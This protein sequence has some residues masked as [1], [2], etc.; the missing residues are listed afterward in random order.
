MR[1]KQSFL[2]IY[3][4]VGT[5]AYGA[6][7]RAPHIMAAFAVVIG[8]VAVASTFASAGS[9]TE[10][11]PRIKAIVEAFLRRPISDAE[12]NQFYAEE[13]TDPSKYDADTL[14]ELDEVAATLR[15][16]HGKPAA[17]HRRH[18]LIQEAMFE[19]G[20]P[21]VKR[22]FTSLDPV[23]VTD[24]SGEKLMTEGDVLAFVQIVKFARTNTDPSEIEKRRGPKDTELAA[25]V[26]AELR[27]M[28][29]NGGRLPEM[30]PD[31]SAFWAGMVQNWASLSAQEKDAVRNYIKKNLEGT[32]TEMSD[33]LY[34]NLM[35]W[36]S[37]EYKMADLNKTIQVGAMWAR[38]R[39]HMQNLQYLHDTWS[40][41]THN[42]DGSFR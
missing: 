22:V 34:I 7:P 3:Q 6:K 15:N 33:Q 11:K 37:F 38:T 35:G 24:K 21:T 42:A 20:K 31:A 41:A 19:S 36:S 5:G 9:N 29:D 26:T 28:I 4:A 12:L 16:Q 40:S 1:F 14:Q 30:L 13:V 8:L 32:L 2:W 18:V 17:I 39:Q 23:A 27:T 25:K 10:I